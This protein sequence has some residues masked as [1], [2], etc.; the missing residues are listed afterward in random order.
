M[1]APAQQAIQFTCYA[2]DPAGGGWRYE[3]RQRGDTSVVGWQLMA[4]KSGEM[5]YLTV[6][7]LVWRKA[8]GYLDGV[9]YESGARYGYTD[10]GRG[11]SATTAIG[12]LCRMYLGWKKD[13]PAL[14]RGA[15]WLSQQGPAPADMYYNYYATQVM[16]HWEGPM[17]EKWNAAMR[18]QLRESQATAGHEKGSW[19]FEHGHARSGGRLYCTAMATMILEVRYRHLSIYRQQSV[20][21]DFPL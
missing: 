8:Y 12:L 7:N 11:S 19:Y 18:Q 6:P 16:R 15:Q 21:D 13:H 20:E 4:L 2:Q 14:Q 5:A 1:Y 10:P 17:W 9:Q 3:P